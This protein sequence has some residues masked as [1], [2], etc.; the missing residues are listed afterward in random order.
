MNKRNI[1]KVAKAIEQHSKRTLGFNMSLYFSD[2][3]PD[4]SGHHCRTTAC[5]AGWTIAVAKPR[6]RR[7]WY[8]RLVDDASEFLGLDLG[9]AE[10][11]F[12]VGESRQMLASVLP[13]E[14][15]AVLRHLA[16][17]GRVDWSITA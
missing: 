17:T 7:V 14:A 11:L 9:T 6:K 13:F 4:K 1:L 5:V 15:V 12:L 3:L 10:D 2:G 16:K 8:N